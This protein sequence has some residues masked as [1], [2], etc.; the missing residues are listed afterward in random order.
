MSV[1]ISKYELDQLPR[2]AIEWQ[3]PRFGVG[4]PVARKIREAVDNL[5]LNLSPDSSLDDLKMA[6]VGAAARELERMFSS[7]E[8]AERLLA[9]ALATFICDSLRTSEQ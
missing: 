5:D 2:T 8:D 7:Y 3:E 6:A 4:R 9:F 1:S